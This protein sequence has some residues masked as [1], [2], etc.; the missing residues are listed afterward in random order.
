MNEEK[1]GKTMLLITPLPAQVTY[2]P[3]LVLLNWRKVVIVFGSMLRWISMKSFYGN[4][5]FSTVK[6]YQI[7][8]MV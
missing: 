1:I 4:S 5:C 2:I 3:Q 7:V 6:S 8:G